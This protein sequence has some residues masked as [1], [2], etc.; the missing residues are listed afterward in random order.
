[1]V[2]IKLLC[3]LLNYLACLNIYIYDLY[4]E[5][6]VIIHVFESN[7]II[8]YIYNVYIYICFDC[9]KIRIV[10]FY[11]SC[12]RINCILF[13]CLTLCESNQFFCFSCVKILITLACFDCVRGPIKF[14]C[15]VLFKCFY[16]SNSHLKSCNHSQN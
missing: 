16:Q 7:Y 1:M 3:G 13:F 15:F 12:A 5:N 8:I 9:V 6:P 2:R 10:F 11:F 14:I 4:Y